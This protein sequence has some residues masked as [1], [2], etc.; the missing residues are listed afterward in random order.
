MWKKLL[1]ALALVA[2]STAA[3]DSA[4]DGSL[5]G[6]WKQGPL[7]EDFT[8]HQWL[9]GCGPAPTSSTTG[10]G[11][12]ITITQEG[13]ELS[14]VGG[15]RVYKTN[16]CYDPLPTLARESHSHDPNARTWRTR[17]A[18]PANDP[19][20]ATLNALVAAT[21]DTHISMTETGRYEIT[22][23]DGKCMADVT[24]TRTYDLI[25]AVTAP[26]VT[27]TTPPP[28]AT[29]TTPPPK[30]CAS[31]GEPARLEVRPSR[32]LLRQGEVFAFH[33]AVLD[34]SG[35]GTNTTTTWSVT[36]PSKK[37]TVDATGNVTV[38]ADA[39][40]GD[41]E[42]VAT[43]AGKSAKVV[44]EVSL[45]GH[46]DELLA[47]SGLNASGESDTASTAV[48][49]SSSLG[50]GDAQAED[51]GRKR[52]TTFIVIVASLALILGV[53]ALVGI[54]RSRRAA[55]LEKEAQER[56][57]DKMRTYE[58][59]KHE[60]E[61]AYAEQM[62][63]HQE[64][65]ARAEAAKAKRGATGTL[66]C[67]ACRREFPAGSEFCP[68]DGNRLT[69]RSRGAAPLGMICP[70]C[71]R[72]FDAGTKV[73]PQD[74]DEL[75]PYAM[76]A[77]TAQPAPKAKGKICPT[78]GGRFDGEATFCGKDGTALVLVN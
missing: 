67:P 69:A 62:R 14:F 27:A 60:Q 6:K 51:S 13:D 55:V 48:I 12:T 20:R 53:L 34:A 19:R 61:A 66:E 54:R 58:S 70:T 75:V 59:K 2:I 4:A 38:G 23:T 29:A 78:C 50:G 74:G 36:D 46:Y 68:H 56:H 25:P 10:G 39:P 41:V 57:E 30:A 73:C 24:R 52:R 65:V 9:A 7:R 3:R 40:E 37:V 17:C 43:A 71:K 33:A 77:S 11:E 64:S 8:V 35:C 16:Q 31:P 42:I 63:A 5:D 1:A 21:S 15:G 76:Y 45:P 22:L 47:Q 28:T 49:A 44:V 18:T 72:G 32:K 26:T